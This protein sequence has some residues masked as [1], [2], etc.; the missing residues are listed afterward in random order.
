MPQQTDDLDVPLYGV[1]AIALA[2]GV[3]DERGEPAKKRAYHMLERGILSAS[4]AG[5]IWTS[6]KRRLRA[7]AAG[8]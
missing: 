3:V 7:N 6:T 1:A 2:A 4:K 5:A 8:E